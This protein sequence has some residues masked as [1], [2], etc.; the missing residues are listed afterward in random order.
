MTGHLNNLPAGLM[1]TLKSLFA[2]TLLLIACAIA[3]PAL[4]DED[5]AA[6]RIKREEVQAA[7]MSFADTWASVAYEAASQL[8]KISRRR[9]QVFTQIDFASTTQRQ[10]GILPPVPILGCPSWT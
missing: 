2:A 9:R 5:E 6:M 7:V 8:K 3:L 4:A 1:V 10:P